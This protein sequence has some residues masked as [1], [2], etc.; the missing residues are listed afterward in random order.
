MALNP[1]AEGKSTRELVHEYAWK[2]V[3]LYAL[4]VGARARELDYLWE[5]R[6]PK[7]LPTY[8]VVPAFDA[9]GALFDVIGGDLL[10]VVH[11]GQKIRLHA[12]FAP[13]GR[14][15][16]VG[17]VAALYDLKR[18]AQA[19]ITTETKDESGK[20]L[21]TTEWSIIFRLDGG[22]GGKAPPPTERIR[23]PDRD[24][25]FRV[26]ESTTE[27]QALLYRLTGDLNPLHAD[28]AIGEKVGFGRP[29]LHG[30]CTYGFVGRAVLQECGGGDPARLK[31][32]SGQFRK[33]VW[34][35]D[36]IVTEGWDEDGRIVLRAC[37]KERPGEYVFTNAYAEID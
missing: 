10:G 7:V 32:L 3:V 21:C 24:P 20:L 4:G 23:P 29:I 31:A 12:P 5:G 37:A 13:E 14:L 33:P 11:G 15:S 25:D 30:L 6:G 27:E 9:N 18:M 34:P 22:F 35:G 26:E 8:A 36:T 17:T 28:P 19:V 1:D 2:D 16:T